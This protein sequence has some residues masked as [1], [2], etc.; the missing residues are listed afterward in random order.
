VLWV[1]RLSFFEKAFPQPM[2]RAVEEAARGAAEDAPGR[3]VHFVL[4]GWF[5]DPADRARFEEA[6]RAYAPSAVVHFLDGNDRERLGRLWAAADIFLSL[7]DNIQETFGITPLEAMAAGLPVVVSDW[8]GYRY[9]VRD[10]QEGFLAPTLGGA[11]GGPGRVFAGRHSLVID[12]YQAYAAY[13]A[14][15]TAVNVGRAAGALRKLIA[16]PELR[17][18]MGAAGRRRVAETFDWP[19]VVGRIQA[20]LDELAA[21]RAAAPPAPP[22]PLGNPVKGDPYRDF[23]GFASQVMSRSTQLRVREGVGEP[24][25]QRAL[26]VKL[27]TFGAMWRASPA[28]LRRILELVGQG[29][30]RTP[31]EVL[32]HF[33]GRAHEIQLSLMWL[34]KLGPAGLA[35]GIGGRA[36]LGWRRAPGFTIPLSWTWIAPKGTAREMRPEGRQPRRPRRD[37]RRHEDAPERSLRR[38][39]GAGRPEAGAL[40]QRGGAPHPRAAAH[41]EVAVQPDRQHPPRAGGPRG[42]ERAFRRD[43]LPA[44][45]DRGRSRPAPA[46]LLRVRASPDHSGPGRKRPGGGDRHRLRRGLLRRGAGAAPARG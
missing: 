19:V 23:A 1:G 12:S 3:R 30:A 38:R 40:S 44:L 13:V 36:P 4:A 42:P 14:Q 22:R 9:T 10:G 41:G 5:P 25:L 15:H 11:P 26:T 34:A 45:R 39:P 28:E 32:A 2:F 7:V 31:A 37:R 8:D 35:A 6:A 43:D 33:P 27:D 17:K 29:E 20:L 16:S 46:G 21:I 24:D 18:R